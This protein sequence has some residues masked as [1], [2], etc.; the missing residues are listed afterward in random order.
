MSITTGFQTTPPLLGRFFRSLYVVV[1]VAMALMQ[2]YFVRTP[3]AITASTSTVSVRCWCPS[4]LKI[5][6]A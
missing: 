4:T 1:T 5:P 3:T 2:V 6:Y